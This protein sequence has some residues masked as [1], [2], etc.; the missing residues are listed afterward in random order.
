MIIDPQKPY[1][2]EACNSTLQAFLVFGIM[3][4]G[5]PADRTARLV[6]E[7]FDMYG[8]STPFRK[9]KYLIDTEQLDSHLRYL[10]VGKYTLMNKSFRYLVNNHISTDLRHISFGEL[11]D[12]P[13]VGL[14]TSRYFKLYTDKH[15]MGLPID[16]HLLSYLRDIGYDAPKTTPSSRGIYLYYEDELIKIFQSSGFKRLYNF[17]LAI[18][19]AYSQNDQASK[20]QL[21]N[22]VTYENP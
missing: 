11:V 5:K 18:W 13:G 9:L 2:F 3:V 4:A 17:D 6:D 15:S 8:A 1:Y 16:T 21:S 14:K 19:K 12:V 22:L 7:L 10:K 20:Q